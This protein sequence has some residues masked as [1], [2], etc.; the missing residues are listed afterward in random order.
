MAER[1][2]L[3]RVYEG[4]R[5]SF[6][7][8]WLEWVMAVAITLWGW[9]FLG[10][11]YDPLSGRGKVWHSLLYFAP[12][13]TWGWGMMLIGGLR[14]TA[15]ALNGTFHDTFYAQYSPLVRG[16]T[17]GLCGSLWFFVSLSYLSAGAQSGL[18]YP[19]PFVI[20]SFIAYFVLGEAG[21]NQRA[22]NGRR[23]RSR[24]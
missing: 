10:A 9:G 1:F 18:I 5:H 19:V 20:E 23:N 3:L 15:L 4:V 17:A 21:D 6:P 2:W 16:M 24:S 11:I 22:H 7:M 8:R 13:L 12:Q 14:L